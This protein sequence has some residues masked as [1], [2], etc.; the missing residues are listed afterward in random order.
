MVNNKFQIFNIVSRIKL[1]CDKEHFNLNKWINKKPRRRHIILAI[2]LILLLFSVGGMY[3]YLFPN[4]PEEKTTTVIAGGFLPD[5]KDASKMTDS[6]ISRYAQK[7]VNDSR[8]QMVISSVINVDSK[9][10]SSDIYIQ[11]PP[12]NANPIAV[13]ITLDN[14]TIVYKS[15]SI[16]V[17]YEV[18]NA[19]LDT[20]LE[21]GNYTGTALFK[22]YDSETSKVKGQVAAEVTLAVF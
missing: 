2:F 12:N 11:N 8:F 21:P 10:D 4:K 17:G 14:G 9:K 3:L 22:L 15:G 18:K 20:H 1:I 7:A 13:E 16:Q 6:E 5:E 19:T